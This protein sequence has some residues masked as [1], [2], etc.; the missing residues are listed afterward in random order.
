MV[1]KTLGGVEFWRIGR[2]IVGLPPTVICL[3]PRGHVLVFVIRRVI[4]D[5]DNTVGVIAPCD[6][7]EEIEVSFCVKDGVSMIGETRR[8]EFHAAEYL[9]ALALPSH[10]HLGLASPA[11][12]GAVEGGVLSKTGLVRVDQ[13]CVLRA[14]FF[15][16]LG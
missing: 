15:F 7:L 16:R 4:L 5:E 12:P 6:L 14:R 13:R 9:D 11:S 3:E 8:V 2:K 1:P 10:R